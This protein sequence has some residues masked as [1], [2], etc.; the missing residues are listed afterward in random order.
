M[1]ARKGEQPLRFGRA[2][3][4]APG[5]IARR[6]A[7]KTSSSLLWSRGAGL[8]LTLA[9]SLA[10]CLPVSVAGTRGTMPPPGP[11]G[12]VD[13][14]AV[15]DFI[16]VA[17][18]TGIAGFVRKEAVLG[19]TDLAWP[20]YGDDLRT[21]VGQLVPGRGFVPVGVDPASV[22]TFN[23]VV[24]SAKPPSSQ[25]AGTVRVYVRNGASADA[26]LAVLASGQ[27]QPGGAGFPGGGYVGIACLLVPDGARLVLLDRSAV[28]PRATPVKTLHVG[29]T[30]PEPVSLWLDVRPNGITDTG[31]GRPEWWTSDSPC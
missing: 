20:V 2:L 27:I 24:G 5:D 18:A 31:T 21:V 6:C 9:V 10:A 28:D 12:E 29:G 25:V 14:S 22:P 17:G 7:M 30:S 8:L 4:D 15:P 16:A 11:N 13:P 1:R 19:A 3:H 26:W 23:V